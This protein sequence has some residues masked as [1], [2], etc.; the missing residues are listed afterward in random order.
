[1]LSTARS[2]GHEVVP[3]S[4]THTPHADFS[5]YFVV[6]QRAYLIN[7]SEGRDRDQYKSLS[8]TIVSCNGDSI[9]LQIPYAIGQECP[10][11]CMRKTTYKLTTESMGSGIQIMADLVRVT[12]SNVFHL[13]LQGNMEMYQRRQMPRIDTTIKVFQIRRDTS[14]AIY[15]KEFRRIMDGMNTK[16]I[17]PNLKLEETPIN[18]GAGGISIAIETLEP[19]SLLSMF[20]LDLD[21][22][23]PLVC[24]VAEMVW[25]RHE[26]D[27]LVCGYRF[28]Q[29]HKADQERISRYVQSIQKKRGITASASRTYWEL[30]DRMSNV[31][32]EK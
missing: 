32:P 2:F 11:A 22:K 24:A 23:Q 15:R 26:N 10:E 1:M 19:V 12:E 21:A 17:R 25:S 20:F 4:R 28:L 5:R 27:K 13:K 9:A 16:G 14:L 7:V 30:L 6:K 31:E 8:G 18:L 29:I 3:M